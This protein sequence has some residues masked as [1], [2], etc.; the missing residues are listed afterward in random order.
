MGT[1]SR[2]DLRN[3]V[4]RLQQFFQTEVWEA[5]LD[6]LPRWRA[7]KYRAS[8]I[9]YCTAKGLFFSDT[10]AVR[11]AALT[12]FTVLSLV[13]LLAFVF[14]ILKGFGAYDAL[15]ENVLRPYVFA[16]LEGNPSLHRAFEQIL[17]F[18]QNT[19]VASL[20]FLGL[21]TLLYAATRLLHNIEEALNYIWHVPT[22]RGPLRQLIDYAAIIMVTP[23][24]LLLAAGVGTFSQFTE[25]LRSVEERLGVGGLFEWAVGVFGP[26]AVICLGLLF[27]YM[28]MP[29]TSVN[30]RS[31]LVGALLGGVLWY[32]VLILHVRFQIGVANYNALYSSF[33]VIPIF[34]VWVYVS[35]LTVMVGAQ[36]A[37]S[38]QQ[39]RAIARQVR[40]S[41]AEQTLREAIGLSALLRV[42]SAFVKDGPHPTIR[43]LGNELD[44]P[45]QL[46]EE[47]LGRAEQAGLVVKA[48][49]GV[50]ARVVLG[51]PPE[52][53]H[54]KEVLD[55][56]R[57]SGTD[58]STR[59]L[60][61]VHPKAQQ[62]LAA[63][64]R[65]LEE[66]PLNQ[67]LSQLL[68]EGQGERNARAS[69]AA[70]PV[71]REPSPSAPRASSLPT[72]SGRGI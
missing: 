6:R 7:V 39:D 16:T 4:A 2:L 35:W 71:S 17:A 22:G 36:T 44:V 46:V 31:A 34:L 68:I 45:E 43:E 69:A 37:A 66:S 23:L 41:M 32:A 61:G 19:S 26:F 72:P 54:V 47:L 58:R 59:E 1:L 51:R 28:V 56:L 10:L 50:N 18:V 20:G 40:A 70:P 13:P 57:R 60:P 63:L 14:A 53:I 48:G 24:C 21:L 38:H 52:H 67:P 11:S 30:W 65:E 9:A 25:T 42:G 12:Y 62:L 29:N 55:A 5:R 64:D 3:R 8:R 15:V 49:E 33:G 27:L